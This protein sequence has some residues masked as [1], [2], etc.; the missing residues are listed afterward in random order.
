[1]SPDWVQKG[2][3][4]H[5]DEVEL[6]VSPDH[7]GGV[8]FQTWFASTPSDRAAQALKIA[9]EVCLPDPDVRKR[10]IRDAGRAI[11]YMLSFPGWSLANGRMIEFKFLILALERYEE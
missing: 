6:T 11:R 3:H 5:I 8:I 2:F 9:R 4:I 10:W 7:L 1:M